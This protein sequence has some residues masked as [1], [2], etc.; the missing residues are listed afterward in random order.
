MGIK[1]AHRTV[2]LAVCVE[3]ERTRDGEVADSAPS[4]EV[5]EGC[6]CGCRQARMDWG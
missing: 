2:V 4:A 6:R 1:Q 3:M 5:W